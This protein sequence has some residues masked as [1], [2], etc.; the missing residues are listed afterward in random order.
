MTTADLD[1]GTF[2]FDALA[3]GPAEIFK[4][5]R[6]GDVARIAAAASPF[7]AATIRKRY[8]YPTARDRWQGVFRTTVA[9][10]SRVAGEAASL[11]LLARLGLQPSILLAWG[12]ARAHGVLY[13]SFLLTI[14]L[15]AEPLDQRLARERDPARRADLLARLG[16]FVRALK[17]AGF[18]DRDLHLRNLLALE[19]G[20]LCKID[21]PFGRVVSPWRRA[22]GLERDLEDL[23]ADLVDVAS[24]EEIVRF[25]SAVTG[26][27]A[28]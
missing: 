27:S 16:D 21:S 15:P 25:V 9:S 26:H 1:G 10:R 2:Q 24:G 20:P 12:E 5:H 19:S 17:A 6:T 28:R 8:W 7:G 11:T 22:R 13:D 23:R 14:E 3:G 4:S 18:V